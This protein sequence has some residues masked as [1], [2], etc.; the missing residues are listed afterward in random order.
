MSKC[1]LC[2]SI[3]GHEADYALTFGKEERVLKLCRYCRQDLALLGFND[4]Q[5]IRLEASKPLKRKTT[6]SCF[7][8]PVQNLM[9]ASK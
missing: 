3:T 2:F 8:E 9:E 4:N 5:T 7:L 6:R 1:G